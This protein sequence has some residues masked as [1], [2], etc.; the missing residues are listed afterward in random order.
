MINY[1]PKQVYAVF[2]HLGVTGRS[3]YLRFIILDMV[4][5]IIYVSFFA[6]GITLF[7]RQLI[8]G[9]PHLHWIKLAPLFAGD[10][11]LLENSLS[12]VILFNYPNRLLEIASFMNYFTFAKFSLF[13]ISSLILLFLFLWWV[14]DGI[15]N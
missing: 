12:L 10:A 11:D 6:I 1:T 9:N 4:Y 3:A 2:D 7:L 14:W 13:L 15:H 5:I 8:P